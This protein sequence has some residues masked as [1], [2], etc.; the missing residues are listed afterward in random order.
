[1]EIVVDVTELDTIV[2]V[3]NEEVI[4]VSVILVAVLVV[5]TEVIVEVVSV[6]VDT[7]DI[8]DVVVN[9]VVIGHIVTINSKSELDRSEKLFTRMTLLV[10]SPDAISWAVDSEM[11]DPT[12]MV[13]TVIF[14]A[15]NAD[16]A[17]TGGASPA[18]LSAFVNKINTDG[19]PCE[20]LARDANSCDVP[21]RPASV[22][23]LPPWYSS[24]RSRIAVLRLAVVGCEPKMISEVNELE[25]LETPKKE[26]STLVPTVNSLATASA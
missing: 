11:F 1:M 23:V 14:S 25:N 26:S 3:V 7:V 18:L 17:E 13:M 2:V 6:T 21:L 12:A 5:V 24:S 15:C 22:F 9:L 8:V 16:A 19:M 4:E 20:I 10:P